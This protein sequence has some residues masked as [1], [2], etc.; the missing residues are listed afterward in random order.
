[1]DRPDIERIEDLAKRRVAYISPR[2]IGVICAYI[3]DLEGELE[4]RDR[5]MVESD[6]DHDMAI[7]DALT[8]AR[9]KREKA[10]AE[11]ERLRDGVRRFLIPWAPHLPPS[12]REHLEELA[13]RVDCG[14]RD[15]SHP[16][17]VGVQD[18]EWLAR[19]RD[20]HTVILTP[21]DIDEVQAHQREGETFSDCVLRLIHKGID[22]A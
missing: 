19:Q 16:T 8:N 7:D 5:T 14:L 13:G 3:H 15:R 2:T 22:N 11:V 17:L 1:M 18:A 21:L 9:K 6:R 12:W 4:A 20:A 10:E